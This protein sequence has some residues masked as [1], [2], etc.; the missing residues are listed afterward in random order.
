MRSILSGAAC[1]QSRY[2][3]LSKYQCWDQHVKKVVVVDYNA[4]RG[5]LIEFFLDSIGI[6]DDISRSSN[7]SFNSN[8]T[9]SMEFLSVVRLLNNGVRKSERRQFYLDLLK[10]VI[11]KHPDLLDRK[12]FFI[13]LKFKDLF[14]K[15]I[16]NN[17]KLA[18]DL[19]KDP[20]TFLIQGRD[21]DNLFKPQDETIDLEPV[22][23]RFIF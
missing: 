10:L 16:E 19:D 7:V 13:P 18:V 23:R 21:G 15:E 4:A 3:Y 12:P 17:R 11:N 6:E 2:A 9:P 1:L 14:E 8:T 20:D 5:N 22:L